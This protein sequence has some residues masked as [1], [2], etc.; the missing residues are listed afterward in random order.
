MTNTERKPEFIYQQSHEIAKKSKNLLILNSGLSKK[1]HEQL[2]DQLDNPA[3]AS[4]ISAVEKFSSW[5]HQGLKPEYQNICL[6]IDA[7]NNMVVNQVLP[8]LLSLSFLPEKPSITLFHPEEMDVEKIGEIAKNIEPYQ[9]PSSSDRVEIR[10]S[11]I[12]RV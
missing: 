4:I 1:R 12:P 9:Q 3:T 11:P 6:Y 2:L 10:F 7:N 5:K 8:L